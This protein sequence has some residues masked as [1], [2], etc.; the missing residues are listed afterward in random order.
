MGLE[1]A[2][3]LA[4][5]GKCH[6]SLALTP[7]TRDQGH[8]FSATQNHMSSGFLRRGQLWLCPGQAAGAVSGAVKSKQGLSPEQATLCLGCLQSPGERDAPC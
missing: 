4:K 2:R 3:K 7:G 6:K 5:G 1:V 8:T